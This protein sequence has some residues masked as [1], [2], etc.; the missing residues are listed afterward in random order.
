MLKLHCRLMGTRLMAHPAFALATLMGRGR[1]FLGAQLAGARKKAMR[2]RL[3]WQ[4]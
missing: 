3:G 2:A 1:W 4:A